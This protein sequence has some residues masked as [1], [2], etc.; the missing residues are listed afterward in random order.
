LSCQDVTAGLCPNQAQVNR[1]STSSFN[2]GIQARKLTRR[3]RQS[4]IDCC[5]VTLP[6]SRTPPAVCRQ[7][8]VIN[9]LTLQFSNSPGQSRPLYLPHRSIKRKRV[10]GIMDAAVLC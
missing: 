9:L 8:A 5:R 6:L 10:N 4:A 7:C 3:H 1:Q 2:S